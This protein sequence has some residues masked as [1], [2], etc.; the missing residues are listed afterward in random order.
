VT[1][2]EKD[3]VIVKR[4]LEPG[5]KVD[6]APDGRR[7]TYSDFLQLDKLLSLQAPIQDPPQRDE[8]LFVIIHQVSELWLKLLHAELV[9]ARRSIRADDLKTCN[10]TMARSKAI[11][12]QLISAW[13]VLLT[14]TT[15]DYMTFRSGLG[16]SSGFQSSGYRQVEYILGNKDAAHLQLHRHDPD[17]LA[18]LTEALEAP[19][20]YDEV[21]AFLARRGFPVPTRLLAR[22]VREPYAGD[23]EVVAIWGKIYREH[24]TYWE[25]YDLAEKLMD[26]EGLFQRWRFDHMTTVERI[27]GHQP[28]TGGSS[29]VGYLKAALNLRFFHDLYELRNYLYRQPT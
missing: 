22:D 12:E 1:D 9:E 23:P 7:Q 20:I 4:P 26:L 14:M 13:K 24:D 11:M 29:G 21:L 15:A 19:A 2:R 27:I 3:D 25:L 17:A 6:F 5:V 28:G 8:M 10:K 16:Q 18:R